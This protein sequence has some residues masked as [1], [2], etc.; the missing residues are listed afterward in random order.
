MQIE[1]A[2]S[3]YVVQLQADGRSEHTVAQVRRHVQALVRWLQSRRLSGAIEELSHEVLAEFLSSPAARTRPDGGLKKATSVNAMRS[4]LRTFGGYVAAAG[5]ST[6][7]PARLV[8]RARCGTAP[9]RGLSTDERARLLAVLKAADGSEGQRDFMQ[10]ALMLATGIRLGSALAVTAEDVDLNAGELRLRRVKGDREEV[11]YLSR[12]IRA[13]LRRYLGEQDEG[14][15]FT[16]RQG[17]TLTRRQAARRF[18]MWANAAELPSTASPHSLR[19]TFATSLYQRTGDLFLVQQALGHS[20]IASTVIYA[21]AGR[22]ALRGVME[23][24]S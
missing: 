1:E 22:S 2:L 17:T 13:H 5:Y 21:R 19:H 9:P 15:L 12:G 3:R 23:S 11:V 8:R 6:S 14:P 18:R 20:S 24:A 16:T 7:D 4:S 10:F